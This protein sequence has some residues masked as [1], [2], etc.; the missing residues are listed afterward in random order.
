MQ[1]VGS[2]R[3][4]VPDEAPAGAA[5]A[6]FVVFEGASFTYDGSSFEIGRAHV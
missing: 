2:R 5:D 3:A 6:D 1:D 4:V